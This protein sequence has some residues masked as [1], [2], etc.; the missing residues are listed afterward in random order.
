MLWGVKW[1]KVENAPQFQQN[2]S[3]TFNDKKDNCK[4][5]R[6]LN[7]NLINGINPITVST[8]LEWTVKWRTK[9]TKS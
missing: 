1:L 4:H 6:N 5:S 8:N 2:I 7:C 3:I 9:Q